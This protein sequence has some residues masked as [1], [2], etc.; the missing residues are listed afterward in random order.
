MSASLNDKVFVGKNTW[1]L[2]GVKPLG[3]PGRTGEVWDVKNISNQNR[4]MGS[5][6]LKK[7]LAKSPEK[8]SDQMEEIHAERDCLK[9]LFSILRTTKVNPGDGLDF[10][11]VVPEFIDEGKEFLVMRKADGVPLRELNLRRND[12]KSLLIS[13]RIVIGVISIIQTAHS[14]GILYREFIKDDHVYWDLYSRTVTLIDWGNSLSFDVKTGRTKDLEHTVEED[15]TQIL[16]FVSKVLRN[17]P[18]LNH[19]LLFDI[20]QQNDPLKVMLQRA[21]VLYTAQNPYLKRK[22][23][24]RLYSNF[25][26]YI[27]AIRFIMEDEPNY[28]GDPEVTKVF[29]VV[30]CQRQDW[31]EAKIILADY[32]FYSNYSI[33]AAISAINFA[34]GVSSLVGA[35]LEWFIERFLVELENFSE[36]D[37]IRLL[38]L[39]FINFNEKSER[40]LWKELV[41]ATGILIN[42][43]V[44]FLFDR[45]EKAR[46]MLVKFQLSSLDEQVLLLLKECINYIDNWHNSPCSW[47]GI[48]YSQFMF[49][50][51]R[52]RE[53]LENELS[54]RD[55]DIFEVVWKKLQR[56]ETLVSNLL[57]D[58]ENW[59]EG[60]SQSIKPII[61]E[62]QE[63]DPDRRQINNAILVINEVDEW[64]SVIDRAE[65]SSSDDPVEVLEK[66]INRG[67]EFSNIIKPTEWLHHS[68][69]LLIDELSEFKKKLVIDNYQLDLSENANVSMDLGDETY[70][71]LD[72]EGPI[73]DKDVIDLVDVNSF[74]MPTEIEVKPHDVSGNLAVVSV[75]DKVVNA[76]PWK[77][78]INN[79]TNRDLKKAERILKNAKLKG[80]NDLLVVIETFG[81]VVHILDQGQRDINKLLSLT[82]EVEKLKSKYLELDGL[83][84]WLLLFQTSWKT[85][86]KNKIE[87][88]YGYWEISQSVVKKIQTANFLLQNLMDFS[89][90]DDFQRNISN[91]PSIN[92]DPALR[93]LIHHI[94][95]A[96]VVWRKLVDHWENKQWDDFVNRISF[97]D[98]RWMLEKSEYD[99]IKNSSRFYDTR[100]IELVK[101]VKETDKDFKN[102]IKSPGQ[103]PW[104]CLNFLDTLIWINKL[105]VPYPDKHSN[106][107]KWSKLFKDLIKSSYINYDELYRSQIR[108]IEQNP[109]V[110]WIKN[111]KPSPGCIIQY[112][113]ILK[114]VWADFSRFV[115][116]TFEFSLRVVVIIVAALIIIALILMGG[117]ALSEM[118]SFVQTPFP[119]VHLTNTAALSDVAPTLTPNVQLAASATPVVDLS[120]EICITL[121]NEVD[122]QKQ[123]ENLISLDNETRKSIQSICG[124]ENSY[125]DQVYVI[126]SK[127]I[128]KYILENNF[129]TALNVFGMLPKEVVIPDEENIKNK[130]VWLSIL[131][132]I[133]TD[134]RLESQL[135]PTGLES[136]RW[137][138][139]TRPNLVSEEDVS[140]ACPGLLT[141]NPVIRN[142]ETV[143]YSLL[144]EKN[145]NVLGSL[146]RTSGAYNIRGEMVQAN[147]AVPYRVIPNM[148]LN[149]S[150]DPSYKAAPW[151]S[152]DRIEF[153]L[154]RQGIPY[155]LSGNIGWGVMIG[156]NGIM[157]IGTDGAIDVYQVNDGVVGNLIREIQG[158]SIDDYLSLRIQIVGNYAFF[159]YSRGLSKFE[160]LNYEFLP[161]NPILVNDNPDLYIILVNK[162]S[163][164][165]P[166]I[167]FI[168][169]KLDVYMRKEK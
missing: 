116:K 141:L 62:L 104:L 39:D 105:F 169:E 9:T 47:A 1:E 110:D 147:A 78:F 46:S 159:M 59:E 19:S 119:Q 167:R 14:Q 89:N 126:A 88:T 121:E 122:P 67:E 98:V 60:R 28:R 143:H 132:N 127:L 153:L 63:L 35:N 97:L 52:V 49:P 68:R 65:Y 125:N 54:P 160:N 117:R 118:P 40:V 72:N 137:F 129:Q 95:E 27:N 157:L 146:D 53:S 158:Q 2:Q 32:P 57:G 44:D 85:L 18:D 107:E 75:T 73:R 16:S 102:I 106:P 154:S 151:S 13:L 83:Y 84:D 70:P 161:I 109:L 21:I 139:S 114:K 138:S 163:D 76:F 29:F 10:S 77:E 50:F 99:F 140:H 120:K 93:E 92:K 79:I 38:R 37:W 45:L 148:L 168:V 80:Y 91:N 113:I 58:W 61:N 133:C 8:R 74:P 30:A 111:Y 144:V 22:N 101:K 96:G 103:S 43:D 155:N 48:S 165:V 66:I 71:V 130:V 108:E 24:I 156:K 81:V 26:D 152:L 5:F 142:Q 31:K 149:L 162:S 87:K 100:L 41:S 134:P 135:S 166:S 51:G 15:T 124:W 145:F 86:D 64:L 150:I 164:Q 123:L 131:F 55:Q 7:P 23:E 94:Q 42:K 115:S 11:F 33:Q 20:E 90:L 17:Y 128:N 82:R 136:L 12:E 36:D 56:A 69:M 4:F 112:F 6:V 34:E 3:D 25:Q